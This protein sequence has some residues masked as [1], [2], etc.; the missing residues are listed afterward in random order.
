ML[1]VCSEEEKKKVN[2]D[3]NSCHDLPEQCLG[4]KQTRAL[5]DNDSVAKDCK[6]RTGKDEAMHEPSLQF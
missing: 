3:K 5:E 2:K 4:R 1:V 6:M